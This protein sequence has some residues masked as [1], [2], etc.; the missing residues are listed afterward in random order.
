MCQGHATVI[1]DIEFK[2]FAPLHNLQ[3]LFLYSW[4]FFQEHKRYWRLSCHNHPRRAT[5][6]SIWFW[7][8]LQ[9]WCTVQCTTAGYKIVS[10]K[11]GWRLHK[12][13]NMSSRC[14][15]RQFPQKFEQ[16]KA[17]NLNAGLS[18]GEI[19]FA[20][21]N[22]TLMCVRL[23]F[24]VQVAALGKYTAN[25]EVKRC[26][27]INTHLIPTELYISKSKCFLTQCRWGTYQID[28]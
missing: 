26:T 24:K 12:K 18:V 19:T 14:N 11:P 15:F 22:I 3:W 7:I 17:H 8:L 27:C 2:P 28:V 6:A 1:K 21:I 10:M 23:E 20:K 25:I 5:I 9:D 13:Y 16:P 4:G